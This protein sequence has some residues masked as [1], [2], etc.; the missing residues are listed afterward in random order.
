MGSS[1][2]DK[3]AAYQRDSRITTHPI[4]VPV[5]STADFF[6]VFDDITYDKGSSVLK[7]L[8]HF[9]GE[10]NYRRGVSRY[11]KDH[12][13]GTTELEDFV[14]HQQKSAGLDLG[15]WSAE[16]LHTAGFNTLGVTT[17][18]ESGRLRALTVVQTAPQEHPRL[19]QHQVDVALYNIDHAGRVHAGRRNR[20]ADRWPADHGT[21]VR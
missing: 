2:T 3:Q 8:A 6:N 19:R 18:C 21:G 20:H 7:Q 13:Y 10:E 16:W 1:P 4:E 5:N 12:A 15:R 9:V 11:L 14:G 17:D